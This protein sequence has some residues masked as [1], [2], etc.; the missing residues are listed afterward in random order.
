MLLF[1]V[2]ESFA[3]GE[4]L[5]CRFSALVSVRPHR[6]GLRAVAL[7]LGV[8]V[9][10]STMAV[11][12][13]FAQDKPIQIGVLALGPRFLP[14]WTCGQASYQIASVQARKIA[15]PVYVTGLIEELSKLNY[16]EDRPENA[17]KPG[18]RFAIDLRTGTLAQLRTAARDL[19]AKRVDFIVAIATAAVRV[20]QAETKGSGIPI[21]MTGVSDP[22]QYGFVESLARPGG[23]ITGVSHQMVQGSAKRVEQF[24]QM[25]PNLQRMVAMR[26][27]GYQPSDKSMEEVREAAERLKI[28]VLDWPIKSRADVQA[29]MDKI[30]PDNSLGIMILPD[31]LSI[32]NLDLILETSLARRVPAFAVMDYMATWGAVATSGPSALQAGNRAAGYID[33]IV[34][35]AKPGDLPILPVDP[36]FVVNLKSAQCL[37]ITV[38]LEVL[39]QADR[40]IR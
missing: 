23:V 12:A 24:K 1:R 25:L 29:A 10:A 34:K 39:S 5:R 22:V 40:V 7:V 30:E 19:A 15:T 26:T 14:E 4:G 38:P 17:G 21:L 35:G 36:E 37:G 27:P 33:R 8:L 16:V 13:A 31:S 20:A 9:S 2:A 6:A 11:P 3:S 18:R 28:E 32:A